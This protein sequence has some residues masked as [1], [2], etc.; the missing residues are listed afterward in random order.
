MTELKE[1]RQ[2]QRLKYIDLCAYILGY[3][4]R[5][6]LMSR[7]DIKEVWAT[8]DISK[9]QLVSANSLIYDHKLRTYKPVDWFA[10]FFEHESADAIQLLTNGSQHII[11]EE[12]IAR[13]AYSY[14]ISSV[15][16]KLNNIYHLL[17]ALSLQK[18]V[19]IEYISRSSGRSIRTIA[20]HSLIKTGCFYYI[21]AFDYKSKEF[22]SFKLNRVVKSAVTNYAPSYNEQKS[23]DDDWNQTV[24]LRIV[25]NP[26]QSPDTIEAIEFDFGLDNGKITIEIK[27]ALVHF[28]LMDWNIA[29]KG[30]SELPAVLFPLMLDSESE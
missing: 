15:Q 21:R 7:F 9:Y 12:H 8:Q 23:V 11:C 25:V 3:V 16:P 13:E 14:A 22:R 27:K 24:Q 10:P 28:F 2:Q 18:Q 19:E 26:N 5:K 20:P 30:Y 17:R 6:L 1:E 29:P 4:S